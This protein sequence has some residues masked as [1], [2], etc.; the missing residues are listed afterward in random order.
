MAR[1]LVVGA[2]GLLGARVSARALAAGHLVRAMVRLQ[3]KGRHALASSGCE[4]I[5]GDLKNPATL[6]AACRGMDVVI[7]TANSML[8]R[9]RGDSIETVDRRGGL[10]LVGAASRA[11]VTRFI[12]TS[13][14]P[15]FTETIPF[16]HAKREVERAVR[17]SGMAWVTLQPTAFMEIHAGP[18]G[19]WN[20]RANRARIAGEGTT[21]VGYIAT[22]DVAAFAV[23][24]IDHPTVNCDLPLA[25]PEPLTAMEAL[26][27]AEGVTGKRFTVQRMPISVIRVGSRLVQPFNPVLG[28]LLSMIVEQDK[29][30]LALPPTPWNEFGI[31]PTAFESYVRQQTHP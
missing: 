16:I 7:T 11:G 22:G 21:P 14:S 1:V 20:L 26:H 4:L 24:A 6:D 10:H 13:V 29:T 9:R 3:S 2:T 8:S 17:T 25:G 19:G 30:P 28:S 23:A 12:Y 15:Q 5:E 18:L 31:Q 27:I